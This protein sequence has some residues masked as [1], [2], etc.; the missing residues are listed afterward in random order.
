[1]IKKLRTK[2]IRITMFSVFGVL[3]L[4]VVA[5][6]LVNIV[7]NVR[8][9]D[10]LTQMLLDGGGTFHKDAPAGSD[11]P[12][13]LPPAKPQGDRF[14]N[15]EEL[16]FATRFFTVTLDTQKNVVRADLSSI[17]SVEQSDVLAYADAILSQGR[18]VGWYHNYR[19]RLGQTPNGYLLIVLEATGAKNSISSVLSITAIVALG[20]FAGIFLL[21]ALLSRRAIRPISESYEK[22]KQFVTD[23]SH[24]L[25]TPLTVISANAEILAMT[26]GE[27]EWCDAITRQTASMRALIL[28]MIRMAKLDEQTQVIAPAQFD[29]SDAVYDA[30]M[31]FRSAAQ[32][33]DL[34]FDV[35]VAPEIVCCAD[36]GAIR[37]VVSILVDNAVKYCDEGGSIRVRLDRQGRRFGKDRILLCV[38]NTY[39]DASSLALDR[40][41]DRFYRAD[42]A[43]TASSSFGLGLPIAKAI[44]E[45]HGGRID[46]R[47]SGERIDFYVQLPIK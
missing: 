41:F 15:R 40:L 28:K 34:A 17:A 13:G 27:N 18:Q 47:V 33:R 1:M 2:F 4:I 25:K 44:V 10:A 36:E 6:N 24:E 26:Y 31:C 23:A 9:T 14:H 16:P 30:A 11:K 8:S 42:S 22:Q 29:L 43:H 35:T 19:Y 32:S 39:H 20:A 46:S 37:Q 21:V 38:S 7:Q 45:Q 12:D 3:L 5:I